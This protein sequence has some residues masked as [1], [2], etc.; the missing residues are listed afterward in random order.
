MNLNITDV[1]LEINRQKEGKE[2]LTA[3][4]VSK[5][6]N[7]VSWKFQGKGSCATVEITGEDNVLCGSIHL[8]LENEAFRENDNLARQQPVR[9]KLSLE[10]SPSR[11][12]AMYLHRDWWTRPAFLEGFE[13]MPERTQAVYMEFPDAYA[14]LLPLAGN[15]F[16][17]NACAGEKGVLHLE[18]TAGQPGYRS[19]Q[20]KMFLLGTGKTVPEAVHRT[21]ERAARDC[22]LLLRENRTYPEMFEYLGWCSWDAFYTDISE[23]KVRAKAGELKEKEV[24]VRWI[25]MDDGWLSVHGQKLYSLKPE[26][27]KFPDGFSGMI[28]DLKKDSMIEQVGVW[29]ALGG[30][31]GGLEPGSEAAL[32]EADALYETVNGKLVPYPEAERGAKFFRDW[33]EKLRA[34]GIDFVKVDGQSAV[35]NYFENCFSVCKAAGGI[36]RALESAAAVYM[37]GRLINCMGMA[38]ENIFGRPASG[39]SRNSDDF[40]PENKDGF[41]EHLLQNAYNALYHNE[42][43]YCDWDMFW[44]SHP[45]ARKHA[46]LRAVSGGPVYFSDKIGETCKE[47]LQPL[48]YRDGRILRMD[49]AA[50]PSPDGIFSDPQKGGILKLTNVCMS[51]DRKAGAIAVYNLNEE[52]ARGTVGISDI[53]DLPQENVLCVD[54]FGKKAVRL[55]AGETL[56]AALKAGECKLYLM[57]PERTG[58]TPVGLLDKYISFHGIESVAEGEKKQSVVLREGGRFGFWSSNEIR[59]VSVDGTDRTSDLVRDGE[60]WTLDTKTLQKTSVTIEW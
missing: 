10:N 37:E 50:C 59:K 2:F 58:V 45:D 1:R 11:M 18:M 17:T 47:A 33:Y 53:Y 43:Y 51:G 56:P 27:E 8:E 29:H 35:K 42:V 12:T 13:D 14:F 57:I 39:L 5:I 54:Q 6:K 19:V 46:V 44:T 23:E 40:V 7:G 52:E 20:E 36:H 60:L 38:M 26:K 22:G 3:E 32:Q 30:Y 28:R 31:W 4:S 41:A 55:E 48:T 21:F 24:P 34:D 16:K 25:L 15:T 49:R 9:V